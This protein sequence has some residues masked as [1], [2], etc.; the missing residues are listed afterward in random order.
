MEEKHNYKKDFKKF[1]YLERF[2]KFE[3]NN[4][5]KNLDQAQ[6]NKDLKRWNTICMITSVITLILAVI[7]LFS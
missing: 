1:L 2:E 4:H 7:A 5:Q 6:L 3:Q